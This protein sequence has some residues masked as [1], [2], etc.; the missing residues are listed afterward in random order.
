MKKVLMFAV[1]AVFTIGAECNEIVS[2]TDKNKNNY[3]CHVLKEQTVTC[4][5]IKTNKTNDN[6]LHATQVCVTTKKYTCL[7][8]FK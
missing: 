1:M 7:E 8:R 4:E 6:L 5:F 3:D 2:I